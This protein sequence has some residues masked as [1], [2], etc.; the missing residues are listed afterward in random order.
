MLHDVYKTL[1]NTFGHVLPKN[2]YRYTSYRFI[3]W[4][5]KT[6]ASQDV[7][8]SDGRETK[9]YL[10]FAL[11]ISVVTVTTSA[12]LF[13][14]RRKMDLMTKLFQE[15]G[16]SISAMPFLLFQPLVVRIQGWC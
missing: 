16:K 4:S 11:L 12:I 15:S 8:I 6:L 9:A 7:S 2:L 14:V 13:A 5:S 1:V 10:I 3:W